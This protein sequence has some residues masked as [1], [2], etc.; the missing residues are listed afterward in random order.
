MIYY[1]VLYPPMLPITIPAFELYRNEKGEYDPSSNNRW[2]LFFEPSIGNKIS[3][4]KGGFIRIRR[5]ESEVSIFSSRDPQVYAYDMIPFRNP[6]AEYRDPYDSTLDEL[7][8]EGLPE[9]MPSV[10]YDDIAGAYYVDIPHSVFK[11]ERGHIDVRFKAQMMLTSDWIKSDSSDGSGAIYFYNS[12]LLEYEA[13]DKRTYFGGNLVEKGLSEWSRVSIISPVSPAE[14][15]LVYRFVES[16]VY[17]SVGYLNSPV[18][19]FLGERRNAPMRSGVD[20]NSLQGYRIQIYNVNEGKPGSIVDDSQWIIGQENPNLD[21]RWQNEVEIYDNT[22]YWI[23]LEIQ[24]I[25]DLRKEFWQ[26]CYSN[27]EASLFQGDVRAINDHD[28]ARVKIVVNAKSPLTWG[29]ARNL[30]LDVTQDGFI[31]VKDSVEDKDYRV[32]QGIDL[33][34][35][36][37]SFAG[38]MIVAGVEPIQ[39]WEEDPA[40]YFF[41]MSGPELSIHNPYQEEYLIF[42]HSTPISEG[43]DYGIYEEDVIINP[44]ITSPGTSKTFETYMSPNGHMGFGELEED[45]QGEIAT[46]SIEAPYSH[47]YI[48]LRDSKNLI[49][50]VVASEDGVF[51]TSRAYEYDDFQETEIKDVYLYD[52]HNLFLRKLSISDE[53]TVGLTG[54][55]LPFDRE[56]STRP[57][58]IN[59]FRFIK[60]VWGLQLG[61]KTL[62]GKQVYKAYMNDYSR[63]VGQWSLIN[64]NNQYYI[65]FAST[66]GQLYL[67]IKDLTSIMMGKRGIDRYNMFGGGDSSLPQS[68]LFLT[69]DGLDVDFVPIRDE[70]GNPI[71]YAISVDEQGSLVSSIAHVGTS[72]V[73]QKSTYR[74]IVEE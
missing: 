28:N 27:F 40:R 57:L 33:T 14:Y 37:G 60:R 8:P 52:R 47:P 32:E 66:K 43:Y 3:D 39:S 23:K 35:K 50:R 31:K 74:S 53:G 41:R 19:E 56:K 11:E 38:E 42:A 6:F 30:E 46:Q 59:E 62:I 15:S 12:D 9:N 54:R 29:P 36:N 48:L 67:Y 22:Y 64:P 34:T 61:R 16:E 51:S 68:S 69:T 20:G 5:A 65:Y 73:A 55:A 58:Y 4:F 72:T 18:I 71:K 49:W 17:G 1:S 45:Q 13:I 2:K 24:T 63:K 7:Q 26:L 44:I 25:W 10:K 21:I 70:N